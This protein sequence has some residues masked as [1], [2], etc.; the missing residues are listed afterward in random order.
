M[1]LPCT[2]LL[3]V[4]DYVSANGNH[5][6]YNN[7]NKEGKRVLT[8]YSNCVETQN[9]KSHDQVATTV[10]CCNFKMISLI[11]LVA[12]NILHYHHMYFMSI[13][14]QCNGGL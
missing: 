14:A 8:L 3:H 6:E 10:N 5:Q 2:C 9:A 1:R 7:Y 13:K 11:S 12:H 4:A